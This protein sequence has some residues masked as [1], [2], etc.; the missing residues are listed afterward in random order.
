MKQD[1]RTLYDSC[2]SN[3]KPTVEAIETLE[4]RV[5]TN[6]FFICSGDNIK[7]YIYISLEII[8]IPLNCSSY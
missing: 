8:S 5:G 1:F 7:K 2:P 3:E 6:T 4:H